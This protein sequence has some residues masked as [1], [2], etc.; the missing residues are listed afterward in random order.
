MILT[1][2]D[3]MVLTP[4]YHV[5]EM[6]KVHQGATSLPVQ[7]TTSP[8]YAVGAEKI[9][10]LSAAASR[11]AAGKVHLSLV[12][13]NP[14]TPINVTCTLAGLTAKTVAGRVLTSPAMPDH[15]T[16]TAPDLVKPRPFTAARLD[17]G[18]L[19]LTLP[20]KSVVV[21]TVE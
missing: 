6:Y 11:D 1:D 16:F 21:L 7:L 17:G 15:N 12:N 5:F 3:K 9:P 14:S 4:T 8:D 10:A 19:L 20:A 2:K 13:A 18:K